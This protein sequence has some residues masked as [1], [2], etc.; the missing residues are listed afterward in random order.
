M[1]LK[2]LMRDVIMFFVGV[3]LLTNGMSN[4]TLGVILIGAS[5]IFT[6]LAWLKFFGVLDV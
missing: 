6:L 5:I 3:E 2:G 1:G 4:S